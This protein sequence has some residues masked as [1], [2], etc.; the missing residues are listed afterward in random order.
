MKSF[1]VDSP[2]RRKPC[3]RISDSIVYLPIVVFTVRQATVIALG[4]F[5]R[6]SAAKRDELAVGSVPGRGGVVSARQIGSLA[7]IP[8][9]ISCQNGSEIAQELSCCTSLIAMD[10]SSDPYN[11]DAI[12]ARQAILDRQRKLYGYELLFRSDAASNTY[13]G[14]EAAAATM[15]VLSTMTMS[16]G[17]KKLLSGKKAFINFD[18]R[19]LLDNMHLTLPRE[20]IVIEILETVV[21]TQDLVTLCQSIQ[22]QGYS[23]ALDDFVD[24]PDLAPLTRTANVIKVDIRVTSQKEQQRLLQTYQPRGIL[25]LAEKVESYAEFEWARRAGYDLFQGY[26]F[27]RPVV[28]QGQ[29]IPA[30]MT[31]CLQLLREAQQASLDFPRLERLIQGD[32]SLSYKLLR[33]ANSA[34]FQRRAARS[35]SSSLV[36]LG[37]DNIRRWVTLATLPMLATN[38]PGELLK[39]SL[40]RAYFCECLAKLAHFGSP[41]E[42]F[43][44]G[45]FSLLDALIDQ[46][47]DEALGCV[48]LSEGV[49]AALLGIA[50]KEVFLVKLYR[51][52]RVYELG[53]W[54]A[55]ERLSQSCGLSS[56]IVGETY[57]AAID[58]A[59]QVCHSP[60]SPETACSSRPPAILGSRV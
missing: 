19:L 12:V 50:P 49:A 20:S 34:L 52:I 37:E 27:A 26:F 45:L 23:L 60:A 15:Q 33:Y 42:A 25:M 35:I 56:A 4:A 38:K 28:V 17:V 55:V 22:Q 11:V 5:E 21:P 58:W 36:A 59:D 2:V 29:Q 6:I 46:P 7:A 47:L 16:L 10:D 14:T 32:V 24:T 13:D 54:D 44:M 18:H 41:N 40:A 9:G 3:C 31:N 48:N 43:L 57:V 39:L 51:L 30:V 1:P 53:D 8:D